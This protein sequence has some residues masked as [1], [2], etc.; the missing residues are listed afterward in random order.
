[1][2]QARPGQGQR[3]ARA[4]HARRAP[5]PRLQRELGAQ[6]EDPALVHPPE[7]GVERRRQARVIRRLEV[8]AALDQRV[9]VPAGEEEPG[10]R[11]HARVYGEIARARRRGEP[12]E[13]LEAAWAA[14]W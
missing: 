6:R 10:E 14:D 7:L 1:A 3:R 11:L 12:R 13:R 4:I 2:E 9:E 5:A 8:V